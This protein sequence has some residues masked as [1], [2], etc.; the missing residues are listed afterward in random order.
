MKA[1]SVRC[2]TFAALVAAVYA[3]VTILT[4]SFAYGPI[5][6]RIAE[7]LCILPFFMPFTTW[8][9]FVG[10]I[11]SNTIRPVGPLDMIF[12][13]L[14][15]LGCCLC[16]AAIGKRWD[17]KSWGKCTLA[18]LMPAIWNGV[19]IGA[20]LALTAGEQEGARLSLFFL[21]GAE[22]A[23]GELAVMFILGLPLMRWLPKTK[24]FP[25]LKAKLDNAA[26]KV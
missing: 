1:I 2:L 11:L 16:I 19:I 3:V 12:G 6:F 26:E 10:C 5:Q 7:A 9:L 15:T 21:Y 4:A 17:G 23:A 20:L 18:C 8:G 24:F 14:A 22:V 13:S 25:Q